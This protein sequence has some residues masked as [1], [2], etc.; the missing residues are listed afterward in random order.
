M[1]ETLKK[2]IVFYESYFGHAYP[3]GKMDL[4]CCPEFT[5]TAME[6]PGCITF[7]DS[8]FISKS[9]HVD[10]WL[11]TNRTRIILHELSHM[12]FGNMVTMKWWNGLWLNESFAEFT[13]HIA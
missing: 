8:F 5:Y 2:G 9:D 11:K 12:W 13:C 7:K 1:F 3:F 6:N 10:I 4:V